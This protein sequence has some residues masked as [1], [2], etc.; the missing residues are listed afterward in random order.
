MTYWQTAGARASV[1]RSIVNDKLGRHMSD[2]MD[3]L[4]RNA[5]LAAPY[6]RYMGD[7]TTNKFGGITAQDK[8]NIDMLSEVHLGMSYRD[9]PYASNPNGTFGSIIC[10]TSPGVLHD[11]RHNQTIEKWT[12]PIAYAD[13]TRLLN[14]EFGSFM[15]VRFVRSP[16]ATLFNCGTIVSQATVTSP[17][18]AGDGSPNTK[19]DGVYQVGQPGAT[20]YIQLDSGTT[21]SDFSEEDIVTIHIQRTSAN[22]VTNGVDYTDGFLQN[23]RIAPGGVD[24]S[25]KRLSFEE[26]IMTDFSTDLGGGVYAYVTK[27]QHIHTS[28]FIGGDDG[29]V[30]GVGQPPR[31]HTPPPVDDFDSIFRFTWEAFLGWS[32]YNPKV[33]E[34]V[35]SAGSFRNVGP[36][37][38]G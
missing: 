9:V 1:L 2:V 13:A 37:L 3:L 29:V 30:M 22:G 23:R 21:M 24:T 26:P 16:K 28:I 7:D 17:I 15:N 6:K 5:L 14:E 34:V 8:F 38:A 27:G 11:L 31:L 35:Y 12:Y 25:N 18:A 20:H 19:V 33:L 4:S 10:I 32:I 36:M